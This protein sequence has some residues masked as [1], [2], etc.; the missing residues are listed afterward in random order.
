MRAAPA[1]TATIPRPAEAARLAEA[2]SST[3]PGS[4]ATEVAIGAVRRRAAEPEVGAAADP[5]EHEADVLAEEMLGSDQ[6]PCGCAAAGGA[7]QC[8]PASGDVIRRRVTAAPAGPAPPGVALTGGAPLTTPDRRFFEA[9]SGLDLSGVRVHHDAATGDAARGIGALAFTRGS[10]IGFA[11]GQ[12]QPGTPGGRNLLAHELANVVLGHSGIRRW[13]HGEFKAEREL[14]EQAAREAAERERRHRAW[15]AGVEQHRLRELPGQS[16][17][18]GAERERTT[19]ALLA[20]QSASIDAVGGGQGWLTAALATQGYAGP[21][22]PEVKLAWGNALVAAEAV[23]PRRPG[24]APNTDARLVALEAVPAFYDALAA[25][26]GAAE[27]A[28]RN[29]VTAT[30]DRRRADYTTKLQRYNEIK[31]MDRRTVAGARGEPGAGAFA[32]GLALSRGAPPPAPDYLTEPPAVSGRIPPA[33]ARVYAADSAEQWA[34]VVREVESLANGFAKL[35]VQSLPD[36]SELR[37]GA[38]YLEQLGARLAQFEEQNPAGVRIPAVFYPKDKIVPPRAGAPADQPTVVEAIPWQLYLINTGLTPPGQPLRPGGEWQLVDLISTK[39]FVNRWP[40]AEAD[41]LRLQRGETVDPPV[42]LFTELNSKIRFPEGLLHFRMPSG[43]TY[44]HEMTE[45]WEWSDF[46]TAVGVALAAIAIVA[47]VIA[48]GGAAAPAAVAF[49]AGLAA[50]AA[51]IGSALAGLHEKRLQGILTDRDVDEAM[52]SI[53]IDLV[54]ALSL[55]LS[56]L[57]TLPA[58]AARLGLTGSRFIVLQ[59]VALASKVTVLSGDVYQAWSFTSSFLSA[60][61]ALEDQP[62]MTEQERK[63]MRGQLIRRALLTGALLA[64]ALKSDVGDVRA[65][66]I[67]VDVEAGRTIQVARVDP[68]GTLVVAPHAD[69]GVTP[70]VHPA[71]PHAGVAPHAQVTGPVHQ[72]ADRTGAVARIGPQTHGIGVAGEGRTRDLYFCSDSCTTIVNQLDAIVD[73]LPRGHAEREIFQGLLSRARGASRRLK[74]GTLTPEAADDI[75]RQITADLTRHSRASELF[76]ALLNTDPGLLRSRGNEIR[77]RLA[78][79]LRAQQDTTQAERQLA[80]QRSRGPMDPETGLPTRSPIELDVLGGLGIREAARAGRGAQPLHFDTGIF[81]HTYAEALVPNLPRGLAAEVSV[82]L[83][84]G[85]TGRA[86]RVGFITDP[87][88]GIELVV[89]GVVHEHVVG[90]HVYEI[91]PNTPDNMARGQVQADEYAAALRARI[92]GELRA[93]GK[94]IPTEAPGGGSLYPTSVMPYNQEQMMAVLRAIRSARA[95]APQMA[96]LEAIARAVF[97]SAPR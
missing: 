29:H 51:G 38:E 9:H 14:Q 55:G 54:G 52:V 28:H 42:P 53:G 23:R 26:A 61:R 86:D 46:L 58:A 36:E 71:A 50:A 45:P 90:A 31:E 33:R 25:F 47:A 48:T 89:G 63:K 1:V 18:I 95:D 5:V 85:R 16:T 10:A 84:N 92:E 93:A 67:R 80:S 57:V 34:E 97:G 72:V 15:L 73:V 40:A 27:T 37:R 39:R 12:Y 66:R 88:D 60:L 64:V 94:A 76:G 21:G 70:G 43:R 30:N 56:R 49:Y 75:A 32:G 62:G 91:K 59:R 79:D 2:T 68:D 8:G 82:S 41:T 69:P 83:P 35:V 7:C 81:S 74:A 65:G 20:Q 11:A 78:R 3:G 44:V 77:Q 17:T 4:L 87:R 96:D 24:E 6:E 22:L 19:L 13:V